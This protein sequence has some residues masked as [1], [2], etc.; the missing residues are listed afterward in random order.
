ML[1]VE[2]KRAFPKQ[3][4]EPHAWVSQQIHSTLWAGYSME[5]FLNNPSFAIDCT[6]LKVKEIVPLAGAPVPS[7]AR[8]FMSGKPHPNS[9]GGD[10]EVSQV[11]GKAL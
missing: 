4:L 9:A 10:W 1:A 3:T 2:A 8:S 6:T 11:L 5:A 7:T